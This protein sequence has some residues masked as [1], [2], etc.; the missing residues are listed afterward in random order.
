M[1]GGIAFNGMNLNARTSVVWFSRS[2]KVLALNRHRRFFKSWENVWW[3][4]EALCLDHEP[5][6]VSH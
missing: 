4:D 6:Y 2:L 1:S 3:E 5:Y